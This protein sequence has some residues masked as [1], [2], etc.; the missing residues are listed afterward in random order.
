M[1]ITFKHSLVIFAVCIDIFVII[2]SIIGSAWG[3]NYTLL[4][5]S[6]TIGVLL[7]FI[8]VLPKIDSI[9]KGLFYY[10]TLIIIFIPALL[11]VSDMLF[12]AIKN[13]Q[14]IPEGRSLFDLIKNTF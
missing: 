10:L 5:L 13:Y 11:V 8:F 9:S 14:K 1:K 4:G 2:A 6:A 12:E 7:Y 3:S